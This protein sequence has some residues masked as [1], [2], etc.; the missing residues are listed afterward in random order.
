MNILAGHLRGFTKIERNTVLTGM[1]SGDIQISEGVHFEVTGMINGNVNI[2]YS[3]SLILSGTINGEIFN[4][5]HL[6]V[7][8]TVN[9]ELVDLGGTFK[10]EGEA[11]INNQN[12]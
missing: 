10:I 9:G 1:I 4:R 7:S 3:S 6:E 11:V 8:G 2:P 5:G 12:I